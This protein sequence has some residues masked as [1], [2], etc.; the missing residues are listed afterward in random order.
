[1]EKKNIF[2][3]PEITPED[4]KTY[5]E[6]LKMLRKHIIPEALPEPKTPNA[7]DILMGAYR[8]L[9]MASLLYRREIISYCG[10]SLVA[11]EWVRPLAEWI[12]SRRCLE[13]MA[14]TGALSKALRDCGVQI[15]ATDNYSWHWAT[16][17]W[18]GIEN[19]D[20]REAIQKYGKDVELIICSWPPAGTAADAIK[21]MRI[22]N[23]QSQMIYIGEFDRDGM[24][25]DLPNIARIERDAAFDTAVSNYKQ[26]TM[27]HDWPML[28]R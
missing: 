17:P 27:I 18:L 7:L 2:D 22:V 21:T 9:P 11:Y 28:L 12:G 6:L 8:E 4:H 20:F 15:H 1:M 24:N 5:A 25:A 23:P 19:I 14:G 10:F 3:G 16:R 26:F 13:I